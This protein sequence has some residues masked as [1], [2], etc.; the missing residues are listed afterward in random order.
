MKRIPLSIIREHSDLYQIWLQA[1][2]SNGNLWLFL[3][4]DNGIILYDLNEW[5]NKRNQK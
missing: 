2:Q 5:R 3:D 4:D 1:L